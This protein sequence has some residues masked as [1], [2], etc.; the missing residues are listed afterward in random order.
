[1]NI[2]FFYVS[3]SH[4]MFRFTNHLRERIGRAATKLNRKKTSQLANGDSQTE[5]P[6]HGAEGHAFQVNDQP[7]QVEVTS[8][9]HR[10][11][12]EGHAF[13]VNDQ[14]EQANGRA[15]DAP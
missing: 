5:K 9:N 13:Q 11:G 4:H 6:R 14:P 8:D 1:M 7:E 3:W 10:H 2:S 12:A 15:D